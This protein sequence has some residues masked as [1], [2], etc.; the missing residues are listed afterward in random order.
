MA[1][2]RV[3][4]VD[5]PDEAVEVMVDLTDTV[6]PLNDY[7]FSDSGAFVPSSGTFTNGANTIVPDSA[8]W[9]LEK[10]DI[11]MVKLHDS[12]VGEVR[13]ATGTFPAGRVKWH[14]TKKL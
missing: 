1:S 3:S 4:L 5:D 6:G 14:I 12:G 2:W 8:D 9:I 7:K 10:F 13:M 11:D